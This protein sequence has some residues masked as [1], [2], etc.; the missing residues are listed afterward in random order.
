MATDYASL[1]TEIADFY[2][3]NDLTS[4][5]DTFI[6]LAEA[7]MQRKLKLLEFETTTTVAVTAG[8]GTLPTVT[9]RE[10]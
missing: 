7:E 9:S 10:L 6:D 8:S 2:N 5:L 4:V 3:R 1:K